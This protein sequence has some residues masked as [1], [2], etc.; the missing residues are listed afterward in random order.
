ML[1][2]VCLHC[3]V[4]KDRGGLISAAN[5]INGITDDYLYK[6][7]WDRIK[8]KRPNDVVGVRL[9]QVTCVVSFLGYTSF[10]EYQQACERP[11]DKRLAGMIGCYYSYLRQSTLAGAILRSPVKISEVNRQIV[12]QLKGESRV[13]SGELEFAHGCIFVTMHSSEG[14]S[15]RHVYRIG[16][17]H[18]PSLLIGVFSGVSSAFTPIAGRVVL[19]RVAEEYEKMKIEKIPIAK[20]KKSKIP[21]EKLMA[22]FFK[23]RYES[24]LTVP[25]QMS[26]DDGDIK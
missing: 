20:A 26:Y 13:F 9:H 5:R 11:I 14:K 8:K 4:V 24:N 6:N 3:N 1:D 19:A 17:R 15:F 7:V 22:S 18:A 16:I 2:D 25:A 23:N 10:D 21:I 12:L